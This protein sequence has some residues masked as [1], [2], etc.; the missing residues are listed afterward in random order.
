MIS[1]LFFIS[2]AFAQQSEESQPDDSF[3][4]N[5]SDAQELARTIQDRDLFRQLNLVKDQQ[6]SN[7]EKENDLLKKELELKDRVIEIDQKE[8]ESTRR[9]LADMEKVTDRAIKL[10][11]S[12]KSNIWE[13]YGPIAV[14]LIA[15]VTIASIL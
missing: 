4:F 14:I 11:E 6:I 2:T 9:A 13:Q 7:L 15:V 1:L 3:C 10:A 8:I 5:L 12:K